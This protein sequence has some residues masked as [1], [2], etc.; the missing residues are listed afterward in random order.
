VYQHDNPSRVV[1]ALMAIIH[2]SA[3]GAEALDIY[4]QG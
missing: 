2:R 3:S 4:Q 1:K